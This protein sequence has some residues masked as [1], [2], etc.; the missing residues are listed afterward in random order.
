MVRDAGLRAMQMRR[1]RQRLV[2]VALIALAFSLLM[3][4]VMPRRAG[5]SGDD[6]SPAPAREA[7]APPALE[8][9][10]AD[11]PGEMRRDPFRD[12]ATPAPLGPAR[13]E[14]IRAQAQKAIRPQVILQGDPARVLI[15]G[16]IVLVGEEIAG[17]RLVG[18]EA[19]SIIVEK[20]GVQVRIGL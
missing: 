2:L 9:V 14:A 18:I 7:A 8:P 11:W 17:F 1:K 16:R 10:T 4:R 15:N 6:A 13:D 20:E 5:A 12:V 3:Y 19:R